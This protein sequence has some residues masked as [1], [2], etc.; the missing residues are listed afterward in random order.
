M[1]DDWRHKTPPVVLDGC[2]VVPGA[3]PIWQMFERLSRRRQFNFNGDP[4]P[5]LFRDV[6]DAAERCI[7]D[8]PKTDVEELL[9]FLDGL[10]LEWYAARDDSSRRL[11][12]Q[13]G[14]ETGRR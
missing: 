9:E 11:D 7:C 8:L 12:K 1:G 4:I 10:F 5:F 2:F 6:I 14:R 13:R 3:L